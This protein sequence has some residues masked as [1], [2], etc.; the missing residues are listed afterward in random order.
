MWLKCLSIS[1]AINLH[2]ELTKSSCLTLR[3]EIVARVRLTVTYLTPSQREALTDRAS[4]RRLSYRVPAE[5]SG[6]HLDDE[7]ENTKC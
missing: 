2:L 6:I 3:H 7:S 4:L 5:S 1:A